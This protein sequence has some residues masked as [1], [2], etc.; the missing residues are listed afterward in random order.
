[1]YEFLEGTV[2]QS[3]PGVIVLN[4]GGVGYEILCA[5][6]TI[7]Q[8]GSAQSKQRIYTHLYVREDQMKLYGFHSV[9]QRTLFR[10]LLSISKIGPKV[11]LTILSSVEENVLINAVA[12]EDPAVFKKVSGVGAK[13]AERIVLELKGKLG[14]EFLQPANSAPKNAR[15]SAVA[16]MGSTTHAAEAMQALV[17][18]GY[19]EDAARKAVARVAES[20]SQ[21]SSVAEII[22]SALK[23]V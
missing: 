21:E 23:V 5:Q 7:A 14:L 12:M 6:S 22:K 15:G 18:L 19:S 4:V 10:Q 1:V 8:L 17:A 2:D 20:G 11:A 3:L 9:H 13:T 16:P